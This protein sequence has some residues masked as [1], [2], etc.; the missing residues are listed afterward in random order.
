MTQ[1][2]EPPPPNPSATPQQRIDAWLAKF[3]E[4]LASR[5]VERVTAL[6]ATSSFW[7]DLVAFTWNIK[8]VEGHEE[9]ADMLRARLDD[10]DPVGFATADPASDDTATASS[11]RSSSSRRP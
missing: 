6:F 4:A 3:N 10:V 8:T 11:R 1:T 7:R 2:L 9:I 5:D